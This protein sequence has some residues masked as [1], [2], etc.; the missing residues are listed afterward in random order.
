MKTYLINSQNK[1]KIEILDDGMVFDVGQVFGVPRWGT[2]KLYVT[3]VIF[4]AVTTGDDRNGYQASLSQNVYCE[5]DK[6]EQ[7]K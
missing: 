1:Q 5:E 2:K 3:E 6:D 4:L 7:E